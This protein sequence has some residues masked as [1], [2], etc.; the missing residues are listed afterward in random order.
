[1]IVLENSMDVETQRKFQDR[2]PQMVSPIP[3]SMTNYDGL[4]I[5][6]FC[7][8]NNKAV[9]VVSLRQ[10]NSNMAVQSR[11]DMYMLTFAKYVLAKA[12]TTIGT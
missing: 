1:M 6:I 10:S 11:Q 12:C 2:T 9:G 7:L 3:I 8:K 5:D 4:R